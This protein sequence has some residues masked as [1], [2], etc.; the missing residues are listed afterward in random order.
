[1]SREES[2]ARREREDRERRSREDAW[3]KEARRQ[4]ALRYHKGTRNAGYFG[5]FMFVLLVAFIVWLIV[6]TS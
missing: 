2:R 4:R 3:L 6:Q 5:C 1:M